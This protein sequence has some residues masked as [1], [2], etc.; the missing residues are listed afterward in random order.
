MKKL[1]TISILA[2]MLILL[3]ITGVN[4]ANSNTLPDVAYEKFAKYGMTTGD[5]VKVE[6]YLSTNPVTDA[7]GDQLVAIADKAVA[8]MEKAGKTN[9]LD[10]TDAQK[11]EIKSIANEAASILN[12]TLVFEKNELKIYKNNKLLDVVAFKGGKLV[13]T[14]NVDLPAVAYEKFAKYGMTEADKVKLERFFA[15]Y[16]VTDSEADALVAKAD[17]AVAV[18][19]KAGKTNYADL[20]NAQKDEIKKIA[21]EAAS[22]VKLTLKFENNKV[23][24]YRNGKLLDVVTFRNGKLVYTGNVDLPAVAYEKFAKYG[25]TE[26]DK[27]KLERFFASYPVTDS[28]ADALV[29]KADEAVAVMEKAGKTNYADLTN[30]QKDEIK[31]IANEAA[32]IVKL[33]LKFE[34]NKVEIYRNGK[35]L[36]VVTFR[37]GKLVYTGTNNIVLVVSSIAIIALASVVVARK[38]LANA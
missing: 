29:A 36:D 21:N 10:L 26:A 28:E 5:K 24:I 3:S 11:A 34:N 22:I 35:L 14:G 8:V 4:A 1:L 23:E 37:N 19:E 30:A 25:M 9:Y 38:K 32:S 16:P 15:S 12:L 17:E 18:M 33:T 6:R 13:Y 20:T 31:K 2:V 27:V 7:E